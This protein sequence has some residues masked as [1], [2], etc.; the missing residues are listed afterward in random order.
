MGNKA[1]GLLVRRLRKAKGLSLRKLAE[2]V[3]VSFVN[4]SHIENGKVITSK[5]VIKQ[6]AKALDYDSDKLLAAGNAAGDDIEKIIS[7]IPT[8]VPAFLRTAKNLTEEEWI[9]LTEQVKKMRKK[10]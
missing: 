9:S 8:A 10:K 2:Q 3:D 7:K 1:L 6:I 5:T 4:I